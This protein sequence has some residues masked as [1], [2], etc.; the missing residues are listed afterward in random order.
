[1]QTLRNYVFSRIRDS[2]FYFVAYLMGDP[3]AGVSTAEL[4]SHPL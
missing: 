4:W 2:V 3:P 1:M